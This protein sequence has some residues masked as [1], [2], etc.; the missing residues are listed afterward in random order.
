MGSGH[1]NVRGMMKSN[2][3]STNCTFNIGRLGAIHHCW[4]ELA[5]R[6]L[7][8]DKIRPESAIVVAGLLTS[9]GPIS[10]VD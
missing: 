4:K 1:G 8:R 6:V 9:K 10:S 5:C 7:N 2:T 3:I